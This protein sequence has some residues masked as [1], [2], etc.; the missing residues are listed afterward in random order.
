MYQQEHNIFR[1]AFRKFVKQEVA[2]RIDEWEKAGI[3]SK[4]VWR[5][6]GEAGF[7]CPWL[8]EEYGGCDA[9][10][11]YSIIIG[12][13]LAKAGAVSLMATLHSDVIVPYLFHLGTSEQRQKW[14]P[15]CVTGETIMSIMMT[16]PNTGSD[17]A[18]IKTRADRDGDGWVLNGTKIFIS[19]GVNAGLAIVAARTD[20]K[21]PGKKGVS[22]FLVEE[23][24]PGYRVGR[25]L[26]KIGMHSQDTAEMVF[27]DC[28]IPADNLL[29]EENRGFYY[30]MEHLQ[31]ERLMMTVN[32]QA[33]AEAMLEM[34]LA[35][36]KERKA[37]GQPIGAFQHNAFKL[38]DIATEIKLGRAFLDQV[39][40]RAARGEDV[41]EDV[42]MA[43]AWIAEM[44][45]R[46]AYHC[47]QLHGGFGCMEEYPI[48]R[49]YRDIRPF[50]IL[51][52]TTEIMKLIV[53]RKMELL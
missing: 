35:Y 25:K 24:T 53:A 52:G 10:L 41:L 6:M 4:D 44:A 12:E 13:E 23:G 38:V 40:V 8:P 33:M 45:N 3:V 17:L 32:C 5:K 1:Q 37:F 20:R 9:D 14:L 22:L 18:N 43:K 2:P 42:S 36:V 29:G 49:F 19:N 47:L 31:Q 50:T 28:R 21:A 11:L 27:E 16:E 7:L 34:T 46:V 51:A 48:C 15:K 30:M 26:D 39:T